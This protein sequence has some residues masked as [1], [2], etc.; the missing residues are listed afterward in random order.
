METR[1]WS[2]TNA[3]GE[4][5]EVMEFRIKNGDGSN[6]YVE[7]Y[8][9]LKAF[10]E[11]T[12]N[13]LKVEEVIKS[14]PKS[15]VVPVAHGEWKLNNLYGFKIYDCSNC[16]IHMETRWNYCPHCGAKMDERRED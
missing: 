13:F 12:L 16:G 4:E 10:A 7:V 5:Q 3:F 1:T 11:S 15:D 9:L 8:T 6:Q 14:V 2:Y